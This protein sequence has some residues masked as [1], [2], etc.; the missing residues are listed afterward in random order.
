[1]HVNS[2]SADKSS[3]KAYYP[4]REELE[5][6]ANL[7]NATL[8][9]AAVMKASAEVND[10]KHRRVSNAIWASIPIAAGL[11]DVVRNPKVVGRLPKLGLFAGTMASWAATFAL[12]DA[13]F[14]GKRLLERHSEK[15]NNFNKKHPVMANLLAIGVSIGAMILGGKAV[16][17]LADKQGA[18]VVNWLKKHK[19][20]D[21]LEKTKIIGKP[22]EMFRKLPPAIKNFTKGVVSWSP[23]LLIA[24]SIAHSFNHER[25]RAERVA[26]NYENLK[27][28]QAMAREYL[29]ASNEEV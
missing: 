8:K 2:V 23:F 27:D 9:N 14:G 16:A 11:A 24:T 6:F 19:V 29:L 7:D 1:M 21:F 3:F 22:V 17:K 10:K 25:I 13:T 18:N 28:N 26:Q 20:A 15:A 5:V 4:S 12:V